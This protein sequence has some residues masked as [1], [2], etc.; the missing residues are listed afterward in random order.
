MTFSNVPFSLS[1]TVAGL[2][3]LMLSFASRAFVDPTELP[4]IHISEVTAFVLMACAIYICTYALVVFIW[5][6]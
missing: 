6:A 1:I 4:T 2:A 3:V 5:R